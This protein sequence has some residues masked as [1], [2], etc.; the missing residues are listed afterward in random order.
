MKKIIMLLT[1][2][3][4]SIPMSAQGDHDHDGHSRL[5]FAHPMIAETPSP[6]TK[7][8]LDYFYKNLEDLSQNENT[9]RLE[10]E[11]AFDPSFSIEINAPYTFLKSDIGTTESR[12]GNLNI[13]LK[14]ANYAFEESNVLLGYGIELGLPTGDQT[15]GIGNDHILDIEPN[16]VIGYK[17]HDFEFVSHISFGIPVN[18]EDG[19]ELETEMGNDLSILYHAGS[20]LQLMMEFDRSQVIN[21]EGKGIFVTNFS[22]GIKFFPTSNEHLIVGVSAG[23]PIA[24]TDEFKTRIVTSVFYHFD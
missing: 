4:I 15:K 1:V 6:D 12:F 23:F 16:F 17:I 3:L 21:G 9:T 19:D 14:F 8:R 20:K 5:H 2:V 11:Y 13:G 10:F 22:P 18:Q 24:G 7:I